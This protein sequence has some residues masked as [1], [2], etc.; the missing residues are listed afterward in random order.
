MPTLPYARLAEANGTDLGHSRWV[1]LEQAHFDA[2][3]G[4]VAGSPWISSGPTSAPGGFLVSTIANGH[5][6]MSLLA[7][8]LEELLCVDEDAVTIVCG[9]DHVRFSQPVQ[10]GDRV[11]GHALITE[12]HSLIDLVQAHVRVTLTTENTNKPVCVTT[13]VVRVI[14]PGQTPPPSPSPDLHAHNASD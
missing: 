6:M 10:V 13:L 12:V 9:A 11:R 7:T 14:Y 4:V 8:T 2:F 3:A 1:L 5:L